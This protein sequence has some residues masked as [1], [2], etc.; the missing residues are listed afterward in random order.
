MSIEV[1]HPSIAS[2][3]APLRAPACFYDV[4]ALATSVAPWSPAVV[5][6]I[7]RR[8]ARPVRLGTSHEMQRIEE[9]GALWE[10]ALG[11]GVIVEQGA[12]NLEIAIAGARSMARTAWSFASGIAW[13]EDASGSVAELPMGR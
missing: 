4:L 6:A 11:I 8:L 3:L 1:S 5:A 13:Y 2:A 9:E 7:E 12:V 10:A